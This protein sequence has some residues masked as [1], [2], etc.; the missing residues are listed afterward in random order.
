VHHAFS[1]TFQGRIMNTADLRQ[2]DLV[3][4]APKRRSSAEVRAR[5]AAKK[6]LASHQPAAMPAHVYKQVWSI[7]REAEKH[8][9]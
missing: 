3:S 4:V 6:V 7:V 8:Q 1:E 9:A 5:E 2:E